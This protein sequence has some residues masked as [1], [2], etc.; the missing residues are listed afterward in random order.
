MRK[1]L[2]LGLLSALAALALAGSMAASTPARS[3]PADHERGSSVDA[4]SDFTAP[5]SSN[6]ASVNAAPIESVPADIGG[7]DWAKAIERDGPRAGKESGKPDWV[8][9]TQ[10]VDESKGDCPAFREP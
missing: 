5:A 3:D 6:D 2:M 4:S 7:P 9:V 1:Y 8:C 10:V